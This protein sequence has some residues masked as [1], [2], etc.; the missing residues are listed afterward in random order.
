MRKKTE[1]QDDTSLEEMEEDVNDKK[2]T[3]VKIMLR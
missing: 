1:Y 2:I 3:T